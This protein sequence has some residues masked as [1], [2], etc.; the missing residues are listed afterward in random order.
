MSEQKNKCINILH[1]YW[2][3]ISISCEIVEVE[4]CIQKKFHTANLFYGEIS[5][6]RNIHTAKFPI[7]KFPYGKISSRR[8]FLTAK[9]LTV[10][11]P[12]VKFPVT[13]PYVDDFTVFSQ[14]PDPEITATHL[15]EYIYILETLLQTTKS[16]HTLSTQWNQE[17]TLQNP[18]TLNGESI[19]Y[20]NYPTTLGVTSTQSTNA[21]VSAASLD[22]IPLLISQDCQ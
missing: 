20:T 5:V 2:L 10:K 1:L 19:P 17:Y 7:A 18:D 21:N 12:K 8:N 15:Q 13:L 6:R 9:Y 16:T 14:H 4:Q 11:F 3:K 22:S